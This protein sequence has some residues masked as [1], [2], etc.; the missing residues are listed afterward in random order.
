MFFI[1]SGC[2]PSCSAPHAGL[3]HLSLEQEPGS[4]RCMQVLLQQ[5]LVQQVLV[6][7]RHSL[8]WGR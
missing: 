2:V 7:R 1:R 4:D 8:P 3:S 6:Q 5:L